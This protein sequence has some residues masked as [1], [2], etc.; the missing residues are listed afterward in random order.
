MSGEVV[1]IEGRSSVHLH[2]HLPVARPNRHPPILAA[3]CVMH[4]PLR[5]G[6]CVPL[7][8]ILNGCRGCLAW[9]LRRLNCP[10]A[11]IAI[12]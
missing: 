9:S 8:I 6:H 3:R 10:L 2:I 4:R 12:S 7:S 5:V 1:S 11:L